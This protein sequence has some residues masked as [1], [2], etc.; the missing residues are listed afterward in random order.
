MEIPKPKV[1][2]IT[3][4]SKSG[5]PG[6]S[7]TK[8]YLKHKQLLHTVIDCDEYI[9]EHKTEFVTFIKQ[10]SGREFNVFPMVFDGNKYIGGYKEMVDYLEKMFDFSFDAVF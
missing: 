8:T 9:L 6:C 2:E 3:V 4:Y 7:K 10:L 5:C 1:G